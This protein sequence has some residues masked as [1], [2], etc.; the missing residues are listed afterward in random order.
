MAVVNVGLGALV[1]L[2]DLERWHLGVVPGLWEAIEAVESVHGVPEGFPGVRVE[3][4]SQVPGGGV[5]AYCP[6]E[7]LIRLSELGVSEF[8]A[9]TLVH[10]LGHHLSLSEPD[11]LWQVYSD[12][13]LLDLYGAVRDSEAWALLRVE[14]DRDYLADPRE[15]FARAYGQ[16]IAERSGSRVL[17]EQLE[18]TR[19]LAPAYQWSGGDFLPIGQALD[20][21]FFEKGWCLGDYA[22]GCGS[23][24]DQ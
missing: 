18:R 22:V 4:W 7:R 13:W 6:V 11:F 16:W 23:R 10:E 14:E 17:L 2:S 21:Y 8:G 9:S 1:D 19:V 12:R 15:V 5:G 20:S 3:V 24:N